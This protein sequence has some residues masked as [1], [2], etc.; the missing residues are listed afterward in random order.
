MRS[1]VATL[2]FVCALGVHAFAPVAFR[3][4]KSFQGPL[5]MAD[6][7]KMSDVRDAIERLTA[8]NFSA[9]LGKIEDFLLKDAGS[10]FY[11]KAMRRIR[12]RAKALGKDVP[13]DY[14]KAAAATSK[15]REKQDAFIK[16]KIEEA[17]VNEAPVEETTD[18]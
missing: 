2:I 3:N 14:A 17:A 12:I 9:S 4:K 16:T 5:F 1:F 11:G 10:T 15:R 8:D 6:D 18:A 7:M 13:E